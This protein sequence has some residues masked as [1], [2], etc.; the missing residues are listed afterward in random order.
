MNDHAIFDEALQSWVTAACETWGYDPVGEGWFED[1]NE[2][3]PRGLRSTLGRGLASGAIDVVEG[4]KFRLPELA[5]D[6]GPYAWLGRSGSGVPAVHWEYYVQVAEYVRL[7]Q[8]SGNR[9]VSFEDDLM[10][11]TVYEDGALLLACEVKERSEQVEPLLEGIRRY[12]TGFDPDQPDRGNDPLRKAK[13]IS[14]ARPRYFSLV[15]IRHRREFSVEY[16]SDRTW[17]LVDDIV[18]LL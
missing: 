3:L 16:D 10:D 8:A 17:T 14:T 1:A 11:V 6:K 2:R 5:Q 18:P 15:A 13:Y 9:Q 12:A 7:L 4:F